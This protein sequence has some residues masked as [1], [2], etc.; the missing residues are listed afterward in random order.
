MAIEFITTRELTNKTGEVT[1]KVR[2]AKLKEEDKVMVDFK[3]PECGHSEKREEIWAEP[4]VTGVKAKRKMHV[5]CGKCAHKVTVL[6]LRKQIA[7]EKK[8]KKK[9]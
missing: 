8:K 2:I 9:Q 6:K 1:G 5:V 7:K 4:F 3:C